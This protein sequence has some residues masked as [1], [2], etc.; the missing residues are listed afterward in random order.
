MMDYCLLRLRCEGLTIRSSRLVRQS[1]FQQH[2]KLGSEKLNVVGLLQAMRCV[3][4]MLKQS[5]LTK[6]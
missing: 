2:S 3:S 1:C 4:A 5:T 6:L